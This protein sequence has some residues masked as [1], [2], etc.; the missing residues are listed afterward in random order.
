MQHVMRQLEIVAQAFA[1]MLTV[2]MDEARRLD[3]EF[4]A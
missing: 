1:R 2:D 3:L 4:A